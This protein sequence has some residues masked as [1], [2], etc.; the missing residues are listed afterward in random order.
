MKDLAHQKIQKVNQALFEISNAVN[1]TANINEL[2]V[3]I[4]NSLNRLIDASIFFIAIYEP[5]TETVSFPYYIDPIDNRYYVDKSNQLGKEF[6]YQVTANK[7]SLTGMVIRSGEPVLMTKSQLFE[8]CRMNGCE[9]SGEPA[10][11]WLGVPLK[12]HSQIIGVMAVQSYEAPDRY[13]QDD[14]K[15]MG[16]ISEQVA[17][18]IEHKRSEDRLVESE[19]RYRN[20]V[21]NITDIIYSTDAQ[22]RID[23]ISSPLEKI[24]GIAPSRVLQ[25]ESW[26]RFQVNGSQPAKEFCEIIDERDRDRVA[27]ILAAAVKNQSAFQV[28]YRMLNRLG[29]C[30]WV[31]E[32]G[33]FFTNETGQTQMEGIITDIQE[34]KNAEEQLRQ[35]EILITALYEI[36][37]CTHTAHDL[38]E[39]FHSIQVALSK[40]LG[41]ESMAVC[42]VHRVTGELKLTYTS[43]SVSVAEVLNTSQAALIDPDPARRVATQPESSQSHAIG[44]KWIAIPMQRQNHR[45]GVLLLSI[46][47]DMAFQVP[48]MLEA[49][50]E[51]VALAVELKQAE[52]ELAANRRELIDNAHR[53]GMADIATATLHNVGNQLNSIGVAAG[54]MGEIAGKIHS[55]LL[56]RA[57]ALLQASPADLA[58]Y[59]DQDEQG[60]KLKAFYLKIE[61][62]LA[63]YQD[64]LIAHLNEVREGVA[65]IQSTIH[66]QQENLANS[67][68]RKMDVA[69]IVRDV[70]TMHLTLFQQHEIEL[71]KDFQPIPDCHVPRMKLVHVLSELL[72]NALEVLKVQPV[73]QRHL[74]IGLSASQDTV[75]LTLE[76]SG[77]GI[78]DEHRAQVFAFGY[79]TQGRP[80]HGL[81]TVA[82][83]LTEMKASIQLTDSARLGGALFC[84]RVPVS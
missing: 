4:H 43:Q 62:A 3:K 26:Y 8:Y 30:S 2:F 66:Y 51:Q 79:S 61:D 77:P 41:L 68:E 64:E 10:E 19:T 78:P 54:L 53:A 33:H 40:A 25:K 59:L 15:I 20:L 22:G 82:N 63:H 42:L 23:F 60:Q 35:R 6:S 17:I 71:S 24:A 7:G 16:H 52:L 49:I 46:K 48:E 50:G 1:T 27:S 74:H 21:E 55:P 29:G 9:P 11:I 28:E 73:D 83:A 84:I 57:N 36:S 31:L 80:G 37:S 38:Q 45:L 72:R 39:L 32:R 5:K 56:K 14:I 69:E 65:T 81:H 70:L 67:Q 34:R 76:D 12:I 47:G 18:A 44:P 75:Q 13:N 58:A